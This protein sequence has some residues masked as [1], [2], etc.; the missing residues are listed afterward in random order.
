MTS[1]NLSSC[2]C[3]HPKYLWTP[4]FQNKNATQS[5]LGINDCFCETAGSSGYLMKEEG[6]SID[7]IVT[8]IR[9]SLNSN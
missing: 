2:A 6:L 4:T 5:S 9:S 1:E 3:S 8:Q 7:E